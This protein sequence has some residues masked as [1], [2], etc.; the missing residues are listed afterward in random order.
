MDSVYNKNSTKKLDT[1]QQDIYHVLTTGEGWTSEISQW[2]TEDFYKALQKQMKPRVVGK[3]HLRMS[4][5]GKPCERSL[6]YDF[7]VQKVLPKGVT[8]VDKLD[9]WVK[10]K[11]IFGD[12]IESFT[13]GL[14]M[15][16]GHRLEGLQE[17]V[18]ID[19]I[20]GHRDCIIDGMQFDVKSASSYSFNKFKNNQLKGYYVWKSNDEGK[21]VQ[22]WVP[23]EQADPFGYISQN[24]SYLFSSLDDPRIE[25]RSQVG[26]L[27]VDKQLGHIAVDIYDVSDQLEKKR[28]EIQRKKD[29]VKWDEPPDRISWGTKLTSKKAGKPDPEGNIGLDTVCSYCQYKEVCYPGLRTFVG[30]GPPEYLVKVVKTPRTTEVTQERK[31]GF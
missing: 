1:L 18:E 26:F 30:K 12:F 31:E 21:R 10:N 3:P 15:A 20:V 25:H 22:E 5:L 24:S 27:A 23:P 8:I 16:S 17:R 6:W 14:V 13:L 11:F 2:V 9:P 7:N 29:L 28:E 4:S 19:G